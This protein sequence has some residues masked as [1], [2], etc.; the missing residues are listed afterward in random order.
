MSSSLV[1]VA[2]RPLL[3]DL[4]IHYSD[5]HI[6]YRHLPVLLQSKA[7]IGSMV[8]LRCYI[9]LGS[10][11]LAVVIVVTLLSLRQTRIVGI[12]LDVGIVG[13]FVCGCALW[14]LYSVVKNRLSSRRPYPHVRNS[15]APYPDVDGANI[16]NP[17][18]PPSPESAQSRQSGN[19]SSIPTFHPIH[20]STFNVSSSEMSV[21]I[22]SQTSSLTTPLTQ[23]SPT[24][25]A[26]SE[27]PGAE[28]AHLV[29]Q[30]GSDPGAMSEGPGA[31]PAHMVQQP[32]SDAV[33]FLQYE[34]SVSIRVPPTVYIAA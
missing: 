7:G 31:E 20:Q 28:P 26:M 8:L 11:A 13:A 9:F 18:V 17:N 10:I 22:P 27:G 21:L 3:S 4:I 14:A 24:V 32:G 33:G 30:P 25:G 23:T 19:A 34:D 6:Y 1:Q 5:L 29:Q 12:F 15:R 16:V 2:K